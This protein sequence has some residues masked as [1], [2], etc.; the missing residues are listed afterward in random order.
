MEF[1]SFHKPVVYIKVG[2]KYYDSWLYMEAVREADC[3]PG[4]RR[5]IEELEEKY[6][7]KHLKLLEK[8][9]KGE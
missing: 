5:E 4:L 9:Y 2:E 7:L 3:D 8:D 1:Y 6:I